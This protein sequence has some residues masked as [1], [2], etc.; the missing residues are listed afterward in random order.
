MRAKQT[1]MR[2]RSLRRR[3]LAIALVGAIA[4]P[5][6]VP[7]LAQDLPSAGSVTSGTATIAQSGTEMTINQATRGAI[8]D[9]GSFSIGTGYGVTFNQPTDG[10]TLNRVIGFGYGGPSASSINGSLTSN[11][12]VFLINPSGITFGGGATINVGGLIASTI[13]MSN[14][15]FN[16]GLASSNFVFSGGSSADVV[17]YADFSVAAGGTVAFVGRNV[18]NYGDISA[19]GGTVAFGAANAATVTL[20]PF[21]DGLTQLTITQAAAAGEGSIRNFYNTTSA[22]GGQILL[23]AENAAGTALISNAG[24]LRAQGTASRAGRIELTTSGGVVLIGGFPDGFEPGYLDVAGGAFAGGSVLVSGTSFGMLGDGVDGSR[25][26]ASGGSGGGSVDIQASDTVILYEGT[27]INANAQAGPGGSISVSAGNSLAA[28][29]SLSA[30]GANAGGNIATSTGGT[31]DI[32]GLQVDA[33]SSGMAGV[34]TLWAP[35]LDVVAGGEAGSASTTLLGE[36]IQDGDINYALDSGTSVTLRAGVTPSDGGDIYF[37]DGVDIFYDDGTVPLAFRADAQGSIFG[38]NFSIGTNAAAL[39][40]AFNADANSLNSGFGGISFTGATLE[41]GGGDILFYGQSSLANGRASN[42]DTGVE[43]ID[44]SVVTAGGNVLIRGASTG[45][46]A[47]SDDAGVALN[48]TTIDAGS[49]AVSIDGTG[50]GVTSGVI[51][52]FSDIFAGPG[53]VLIDGHSADADG[54][55]AYGSDIVADGGNISLAG[56]GGAFGVRFDGGLYSYGGDIVVQGDGGSGDGIVLSGPVDSDGGDIGMYGTSADATGLLFGGGY[57][58]GI[59]SAGGD[60]T[61]TGDGATGGVELQESGTGPIL[62][63]G[64]SD[65]NEIDSG[66]GAITITGTASAANAIGVYSSG[67]DLVGGAGDV[68]IDGSAPLGIGVLF[69]NDAGVSTTTGAITLIGEGANFGLDIADGAIDT[70]SGDISMIGDALDPGATAGVRVTGAGLSTNGGSI[71][72]SGTSAGGVGVQLGDGGPF[73]IGTGG[74]AI[75]INGSGVTSGVWMAGNAVDSGGGVIDVIG[76]ASGVNGTGVDLTNAQLVAGTGDVRVFGNAAAGTGVVF[77]GQ[78]GISTTTG[79]IGV[80]GIGATVGLALTGG[81]LTTDSGHFDL[82]GRGTG[83]ASDGLVIGAGMDIATNGGGIELSGD[84]G[85]GAGVILASGASVD[86]GNS[87]V[88]IRAGNDGSSDALRIGGSIAS[89]LGVN[90]RPGGVDANG[91]LTERVND[92][93]LIGGGSTGFALSGAELALIDSPQ[94]IIGSNLHAG[95]V[96]VLGGITRNGN[97][98]LQNDGGSGGIDLQGAVNVGGGVLAL[99]SGGDITQASTGAI[100]AHSL[101][102]RAGGSV[103]LA[104]ANNNVAATTLAG[105]AG[106]DFEYQDV[107]ALAIGNV[108]ALGMDAGAN[109]LASV[110]ASGISAG[111]DVFV[112]NL[113]GDLTLNANVSGTNIDLVTANTLQNAAG[114]S[115]VAGGDWRV[116]ANSWV[117]ETRGGLSGD[118]NLPNLYGCAYLGQC[119]VTVPGTDNHFIYVQQPIA[120]ITFD[121]FSR[122]YG[123]PNPVFTF[124]VSGA[125]LGDSAANVASGTGTTTATIGSNVGNYPITGNF[126][127]A[128]GYQI[129]FAPGTLA[130]T[131]A[132]L[133]FTADS[134]VRYLGTENPLFTGTVTGFRNGDTV[135]S[136]F[137]N[138]VIWT[139]PAGILSP[140]GFYPI[141]G[142]TSATNYVFTQAP[143]NATALQ[144]IPLPQLSSTPIDL[145][146]ETVNTYVYDR[147]FGGA[148]TCA[149]NASLED[150]QLVSMG[151]E[152]SNEWSKVRSRPNLTNCFETDRKNSCGDF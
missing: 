37:G 69:A 11:G 150:Q 131:P 100:T 105:S 57:Y 104:S 142:G 42:Y 62:L 46:D 44:T 112:R 41:S 115:L 106:G 86:A 47:G 116:W 9:W 13:N 2:I 34:W 85:S 54:L 128:A 122:E 121:N 45:A 140:I 5:L 74:G 27:A 10:V 7:A 80:T 89:N 15:D 52:G 110:G 20:D 65:V 119:G 63:F 60:I 123:L 23:R 43:L 101:L 91:G 49:G 125:I 136:V 98:T 134:F 151:D 30:R 56:I 126:T 22:D 29:G 109:G 72:V 83:A 17:N 148:P 120:L 66:G 35:N 143:G 70:D 90:L 1:S 55:Y 4:M 147:N 114:A 16:E 25:I 75:S 36:E 24:T 117:G 94:L 12:T 81:T 71:S 129:R 93:I 130:I 92:E 28:F 77:A 99:S 64:P 6:A 73:A 111:G 82:R 33:G 127:S 132:M 76:A 51:L 58:S 138:G 84:G 8:I 50:Q 103:L 113:A 124:T 95:A 19:P 152:L 59:V 137:G 145:I 141:N 149:V 68:T 133:L 38:S 118:G 14:A 48:N 78:S 96:Q 31:F 3:R 108:S 87:L 26:D 32:R 67:I 61:L 135:Q 18:T 39:S 107:D 21:G 79:A 102:A 139:S 146:R 97:L 144:I 88:V 53:G 40:M